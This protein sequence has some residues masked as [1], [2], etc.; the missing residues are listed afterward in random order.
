MDYILQLDKS[1]FYILNTKY[2]NYFLDFLMP[3]ITTKA[4]FVGLI[5]FSWVIIFILGKWKD[6][7]TLI[8]VVLAVLMSDFV[9]DVLKHL[10]YRVRPCNALY[11]IRLLVGCTSSFSFPS[12]H[13]T[14]AFAVAVYLSY[15]YRR[16]SPAFL[17]FAVLIAYSRIYVGVHYP[18]DVLGGAFAGSIGA[19]FIIEID[20]KYIP[21]VVS[22][23]HKRYA[24]MRS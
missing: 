9:A 8:I 6:R 17:L 11:D 14:N 13:A 5:L 24:G 16:Y 19:I 22:W 23:L 21:V 20:K 12:G 3:F 4:N 18:L 1:L 7:R 15:A 2:T 10:V